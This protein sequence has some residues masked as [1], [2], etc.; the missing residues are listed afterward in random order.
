MDARDF[1]LAQGLWRREG[2][3]DGEECVR[4]CGGR[5]ELHVCRRVGGVDDRNVPHQRLCA[6]VVR[7]VAELGLLRRRRA[8]ERDGDAH[9][10]QLALALEL[11]LEGHLERVARRRRPAREQQ[12]R[13]R[14]LRREETPLEHAER[15]VCGE[16]ARGVAQPEDGLRAVLCLVDVWVRLELVARVAAEAELHVHLV[17]RG[18]GDEQLQPARHLHALQP[19]V[20]LHGQRQLLLQQQLHRRI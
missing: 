7:H 13:V 17:A 9:V 3:V 4:R 1:E 10:A 18:V 2:D 5:D 11:V 15:G 8:A 6:R 19:P 20:P 16:C 14:V 12:R